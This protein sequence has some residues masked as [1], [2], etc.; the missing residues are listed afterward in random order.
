M[1]FNFVCTFGCK[2]LANCLL[3]LPYSWLYFN[4][5]YFLD[6]ELYWTLFL[7]MNRVRRYN[8]S[9]T[10]RRYYQRHK[11]EPEFKAKM[12]II[13]MRHY[14]LHRKPSNKSLYHVKYSRKQRDR[15]YYLKISKNKTIMEIRRRNTRLRMRKYRE[16]R[17]KE[18]YE[19]LLKK[20]VTVRNNIQR[21][22]S[23][24]TKNSKL[25]SFL[26]ICAINKQRNIWCVCIFITEA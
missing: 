22:R 26:C 24:K 23:K 7:I 14:Y 4:E 12:R 15:R 1:Y 5:N 19:K 21:R 20:K 17:K 2:A 8:R 3:L 16:A 11:N 13:R 25:W 10:F 18:Y 6:S 9:E